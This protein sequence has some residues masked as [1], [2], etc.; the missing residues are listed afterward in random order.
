MGK[1]E[2][3]FDTVPKEK[4]PLLLH[5]HPMHIYRHKVLKQA[6]TILSYVLLDN[7][8]SDIME[9]SYDY[10][11]RITSYNVCY[12][13]LLRERIGLYARVALSISANRF[14]TVIAES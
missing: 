10:Y 7:V 5:F 14:I 12:T 1:A 6:D 9:N 8:D 3:D 4:Y 2:W 11:N 13:K